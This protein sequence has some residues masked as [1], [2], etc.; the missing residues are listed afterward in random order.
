MATRQAVPGSFP[1]APESKAEA[2][3]VRAADSPN[4]TGTCGGL[5]TVGDDVIFDPKPAADYPCAE[6]NPRGR[7]SGMP[8]PHLIYGPDR[9]KTPLFRTGDR[10]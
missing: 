5:A 9:I 10:G 6:C 4:C 2:K 1:T 8:L 7:L 3:V